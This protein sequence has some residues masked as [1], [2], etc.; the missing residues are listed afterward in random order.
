[1]SDNEMDGM[2]DNWNDDAMQ[3]EDDFRPE[4][5]DHKQ[6]IEENLDGADGV[7]FIKSLKKISNP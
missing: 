4:D 5:D 2:G 7:D 6:Q 1:M 3:E